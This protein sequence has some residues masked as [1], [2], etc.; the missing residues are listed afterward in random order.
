METMNKRDVLLE[1]AVA[2]FG[3]PAT[4]RIEYV[5]A[6]LRD[7]LA[8]DHV[9]YTD[10]ML[11]VL[12]NGVVFDKNTDN[13]FTKYIAPP[14][15]VL[16]TRQG[17][18]LDRKRA[19]LQLTGNLS[20]TRNGEFGTVGGGKKNGKAFGEFKYDYQSKAS[21]NDINEGTSN[22]DPVLAELMYKWF[23]LPNGKVLDPFGGEQTKGIVAGYLHM[24][25]WGCEIRQDQVDYN[26]SLTAE[27]PNVNY[28]CSDSSLIDE[29]VA[30]RDFDFVFTSPPY[31][32]LEVYSANEDDISTMGTYEEFIAMMGTIYKKCA[33]M[34]SDDRFFV[35]KVGEIRDKKTGVYRN[36]VGDTIEA[37]CG[38]GL[39]YY[40]EIILLNAVG[41]ASMRASGSFRNR[42]IVKLHQ[43][44]LVF[45]KGDVRK[46]SSL[47]TQMNEF[48][49][50]PVLEQVALF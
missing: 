47:Y 5:R 41:T 4:K 40:N 31:Y 25:Y 16:D 50:M 8:I 44:V 49:P 36:F 42:K 27:L 11:H 20:A 1:R 33:E 19:W 7:E 32:D 6:A 29:V 9:E 22:F 45:F 18:W 10:E 48:N 28:I 3:E 12:L 21:Y 2:L 38:L 23:N 15:S 14:F 43:N 30:D 13:L 24:P 37:L 46:I 35:V 39:N 34:L 26:V 17:Y